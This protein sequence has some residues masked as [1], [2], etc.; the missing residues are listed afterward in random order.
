MKKTYKIDFCF[1]RSHMLYFRKWLQIVAREYLLYFFLTNTRESL[2]L[3]VCGCTQDLSAP[4]YGLRVC[5][6][7]AWIK[8]FLSYLVRGKYYFF[9]SRAGF[10]KGWLLYVNYL[11]STYRLSLCLAQ[12]EGGWK[13]L[14]QKIKLWNTRSKIGLGDASTWISPMLLKLKLEPLLCTNKKIIWFWG[15]YFTSKLNICKML[16]RFKPIEKSW[17]F[18]QIPGQWLA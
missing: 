3:V 14:K 13:G 17:V 2:S 10:F 8:R 16:L 1:S 15:L 4:E 7:K 18:F 5:F 12:T 11:V 6:H 9:A